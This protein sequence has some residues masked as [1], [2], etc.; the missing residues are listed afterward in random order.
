MVKK[1]ILIL[2]LLAAVLT[3]CTDKPKLSDK[4]TPVTFDLDSIRKRG[5]LIAITDYN[6]TNY[7][8]YKGEP[9]GFHYELLKLFAD[10]KGLDLEIINENHLEHAFELLNSGKADL[11][12]LSLTINSSRKKE[13]LFTDPISETRQVLVQRKP[14]NWRSITADEINR[15]II[16]N[17]LDIAGK[18]VYV[19][20][21]SSHLE[22]LKSL[23]AEIGDT[24]YI[25]EVPFEAEQL[26]K[27][28]SNGD[29]DYTICDENIAMVNSTYY[30]DIDINTPVSFPQ[31]LAWGVRKTGSEILLKELNSWIYSFR[32]T[33]TYAL[34]YAKYYKN[35]R[36]STIIRSDYYSLSTGKSFKMG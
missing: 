6:S 22:R 27:N 24:I 1:L 32:K 16:R 5:K 26:I 35:S 30:P 2:E 23:S 21:G 29:I 3:S 9:M 18:T 15:Q 17:Q 10:H 19:Q 7:F 11:L 8:I 4:T 12:A 20:A 14:K 13:I 28:V 33:G 25:I 36:S 31:N 34:L